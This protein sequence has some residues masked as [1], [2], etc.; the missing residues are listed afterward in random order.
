MKNKETVNVISTYTPRK[1]DNV[2]FITVHLKPLP[3]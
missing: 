3:H 1:E 2:R